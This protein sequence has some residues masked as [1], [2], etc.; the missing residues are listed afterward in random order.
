VSLTVT[1]TT[2]AVAVAAPL[3][4]RAAD[5]WGKRRVIIVSAFAL[6]AATFLAAT[7]STLAQ[8][9]GWRFV[10]G[11]ATP[12]VFASAVAF[13]HDRWEPSRVGTVMAFYVSGTVIGGFA[14]RL[15]SGEVASLYGW[16]ASFVAVALLSTT[17]AIALARQL[18]R[19]HGAHAHAGH[20]P[21]APSLRAH[22]T[23]RPLVGT[24]AAGF[25]ILFAQIAVFTYVAF[26]LAAAPFLLSTAALGWLYS[27]Y[28]GGAIATPLSGRVIDRF[29]HRA[30]LALA[31][32]VGVI[33][34]V[35]TL[36]PRL[37][38]I[39]VG[40]GLVS[41]GVFIA[42]ASA[43]SHIGAVATRDRG[44]AVGLYATCY[45]I[46]GSVGGALPALFWTTGGWP[47]CVALVIAVQL[48]TAALGWTFWR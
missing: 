28:L 18:P 13:I 42:Q 38:A 39:V 1:A 40:L 26:H 16:R 14:G 10:Q 33:G 6:A 7:S 20:G 27:V 48:A 25:F 36:S 5:V 22:L 11:L 17:C 2:L 23:S 19:D 29:G 46:G 4:G 24:Y 34:A 47:A 8:L 43:N 31:M 44:L 37:P 3:I 32:A 45:Y 12:G 30:G 9:I 15:V 41:S 21:G 35:A